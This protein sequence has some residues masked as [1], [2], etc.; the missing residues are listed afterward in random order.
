MKATPDDG[1]TYEVAITMGEFALAPEKLT[2][3]GSGRLN[4]TCPGAGNTLT[5]FGFTVSATPQ[6]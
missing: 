3:S 5:D 1:C 2:G 4:A 6:K